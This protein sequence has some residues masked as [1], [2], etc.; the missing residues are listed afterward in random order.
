MDDGIGAGD[1]LVALAQVGQVGK[2]RLAVVRAIVDSVDVE[3][4]VAGRAEVPDD[5]T[6]G[7]A[8]PPVTTIRNQSTPQRMNAA[9]ARRIETEMR[10]TAP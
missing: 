1:D 2:D 6:T 4:V 7:L 9:A 8:A 5:P 3:D 10:M